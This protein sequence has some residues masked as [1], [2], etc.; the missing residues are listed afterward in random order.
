M[1][2][3]DEFL[4]RCQ[5]TGAGPQRSSRLAGRPHL[6]ALFHALGYRH[7]VEVGVWQGKFAEKICRANPGVLLTC[8]DPW[9]PYADYR[10]KKNDRDR[11][12]EA[13]A[14]TCARLAPFGCRILR[15]TSLE[16]AA[17]L[18]DRSQDFV[19]IDANHEQSYVLQDLAAWIPKIRSGGII[20]GHDYTNA[21]KDKDF[22]QVRAAVDEYTAAHAIDPWFVLAQERTASFFWMVR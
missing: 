17:S 1:S 14:E 15:Q 21:P 22:I 18:P 11:L 5:F 16:A 20:A 8:V 3:L 10:E 19:Y 13:Y 9:A 7:G 4:T 6:C 2:V 12:D